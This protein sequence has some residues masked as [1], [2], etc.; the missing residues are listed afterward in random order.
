M[1]SVR[2][3]LDELTHP[4][5][6]EWVLPSMHAAAKATFLAANRRRLSLVDCTSFEVMRRLRITRAFAVDPHFAE[7]GFEVVPQLG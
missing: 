7:Q 1:E 6:V 2:A 4:F 5:E 3:L